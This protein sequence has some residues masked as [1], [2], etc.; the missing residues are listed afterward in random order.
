MNKYTFVKLQILRRIHLREYSINVETSAIFCL[1]IRLLMVA[2]CSLLMLLN[3]CTHNLKF[4][5]LSDTSMR[6]FYVSNE[7]ND[8]WSGALSEPTAERT[9][10]PLATLNRARDVIRVSKAAGSKNQFLVLVR[11]GTY[12]LAD[13]FILGPEDTGTVAH[14]LIFKAFNHEHPVISGTRRISNFE[15]YKGKILKADL[16]G[17]DLESCNIRQLFADGKRQVLARFPDFDPM[18]PIGGG[19]LYVEKTVEEGS[20]IKFMYRDGSIKNWANPENTEVFI[21]PGPNYWNNILPVREIDRSNHI[22]TL[23]QNASYAIRPGN[24]YYFQNILDELDSPGEWYFNHHEKVLYFWPMN[25]ASLKSVYIPFLETLVEIKASS[26]NDPPT[27]I[28]F[29]GFTLEGCNGSA[30]VVK[31]AKRTAISGCTISNAGGRGIEIQGGFEN[32]VIGN[33]VY[34]VGGGGIVISGGDRKT[35]TPSNHRVENNYVH[36]VGVFHK[37]SSGIDCKGV[38]NIVSHNLIHSTPRIG[39]SFDG[40]DHLIEYNHVHHVNQETQ[41]SGVIYSCARDWTKRGNVV[42]FNYV[43]DS[44]GY[45]RNNATEPWKTPFYTWGIYLDDWSSGTTV[46]GNIVAN[47]HLGGILIHNG[48]DNIVENNVIIEGGTGQMAYSFWPVTY[49]VLSAM[50]AKIKEMG[51]TKYPQLSMIKDDEKDATMSGNSFIRNIVY[52]TDRNSVLYSVYGILDIATTVSNNN[53]IYHTGSPLLVPFTKVP[54]NQQWQAWQG[55]G[56]DQHSLI[57]DPLFADIKNGDFHLSPD[58]P[59]LKMGFKPIPIDKIG[60]YQDPLRASWPIQEYD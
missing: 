27:D 4:L 15:T 16:N 11:G 30:V 52:Y 60:P 1:R 6:I 14:P 18:N 10:G 35:L 39:I 40:N 8:H 49:T 48:R 29:E 37:T 53:L 28:R 36:N 58:S 22:I 9:D 44:G 33:D 13:T 24:R 59:A 21:Y 46:Y 12:H 41:D 47:T 51:Y 57:A 38:G 25:E 55:K 32:T 23:S 43:H 5:K 3:G 56:L 17:T 19:F 20:K 50:F 31:G 42:Q 26:A 34:E 45:G 2:V 54:P 7:G